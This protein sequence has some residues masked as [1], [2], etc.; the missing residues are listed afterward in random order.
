VAGNWGDNTQFH[1]SEREPVEIYYGDMDGNGYIDPII[2]YYLQGASWPMASRD[3]MTDQ[4][5]SLRQ[6]FPKYDGYADAGLK[7]IFT[8]EQ[9]ARAK[10][11]KATQLSTIWLENRN[12]KFVARN[13]PVQAD[14][15]PVYAIHI[16]DFNRD[17]HMDVLL[18]GNVEQTR[19]KI[20]KVDANHG[21]LMLGD[22]KGNFR[23]ATPL[24]SGLK[25]LGCVRDLQQIG[26]RN[27]KK[28]LMA[29]INNG[30]PVFLTY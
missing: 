9:L 1:A 21:T 6:K 7:D 11:L 17:G 22:G 24:E 23:Y 25:I 15:A 27:G 14:F 20:G 19:V 26:E 30:Q 18:M 28:V 29:G 5:V 2:C 8:E 16:D 3:E 13:F 4:I 10:R 12:G